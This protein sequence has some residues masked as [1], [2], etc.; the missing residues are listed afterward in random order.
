M[1]D[2]LYDKV[3]VLVSSLRAEYAELSKDGVL[4]WR[5]A[6]QL[7][8]HAGRELA[9]MVNGVNN[10]RPADRKTLLRDAAEQVFDQVIGPILARKLK[11]SKWAP[12]RWTMSFASAWIVPAV[13]AFWM[14]TA[15]AAFDALANIVQVEDGTMSGLVGLSAKE[16]RFGKA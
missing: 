6:V 4:S 9:S 8:V 1:S 7:T 11:A 15:E 14:Q 12:V 16:V 5:E 10:L 13:R 3:T 2:T